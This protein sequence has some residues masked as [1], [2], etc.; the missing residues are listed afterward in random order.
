MRLATAK[1][2]ENEKVNSVFAVDIVAMAHAHIMYV[3]FSAFKKGVTG[4]QYFGCQN[5]KKHLSTLAKLFGVYE[6]I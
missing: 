6:L 2:S 5:L 1:I 3:T 4:D